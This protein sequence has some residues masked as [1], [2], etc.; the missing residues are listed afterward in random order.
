MWITEKRA[1]AYCLKHAY[2]QLTEL[3]VNLMLSVL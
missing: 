1:S 3:A 2:E